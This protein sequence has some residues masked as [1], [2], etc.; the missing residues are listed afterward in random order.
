MSRP[1]WVSA[2]GILGVIFSCFGILG[3][4]QEITLPQTMKMQKEMFHSFEQAAAKNEASKNQ[5][6]PQHSG[7]EKQHSADSQAFKTFEKLWDLPEWFST[8][9]VFSGSA[10]AIISA[11]YLYAA[12]S[13]LLL[14]PS[15]I[16]L[17]YWAAGASIALCV[18]KSIVATFATS[19]IGIA[20][21]SG[22]AAGALIDVVLLVI[23]A[24]SEKDVFRKN[25]EANEIVE[26]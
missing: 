8:W 26:V 5:D 19:F 24:T 14:K 18:A 10:K 16:R 12:I 17:F 6:A 7:Q 20:I 25:S 15:S 1:S 2:V 11:F 13:L 22:S 3:S 4:I 9:S 21:L 23:V